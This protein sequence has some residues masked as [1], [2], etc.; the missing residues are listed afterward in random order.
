M[1]IRS[2]QKGG[3]ERGRDCILKKYQCH[4][5]QRK[6]VEISQIKGIQSS[7]YETQNPALDWNLNWRGKMSQRKDIRSTDKIGI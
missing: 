2:K 4:E 6:T 1:F 5:R 7:D 3:G